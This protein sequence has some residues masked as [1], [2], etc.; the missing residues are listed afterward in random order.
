[1]G[2]LIL[3]EGAGLPDV[4][5]LLERR[6]G[7]YFVKQY[8]PEKRPRPAFHRH[9]YGQNTMPVLAFDLHRTLTPDIGYPL[10]SDPFPGL[11]EGMDQFVARGCCLHVCTASMDFPDQQIDDAR[12]ALATHWMRAKGLP[13]TFV[14]PNAEASS[15][16]D[17]RGITVPEDPDW[18]SLWAQAEKQ[19][20]KT[21]VI[22]KKSGKYVRRDDLNPAGRK[23]DEDEY[24]DGEDV[25]MDCPRGFTTPLI[26]IDLHRTL[27]PGWGTRRDAE[28][29]ADGVRC[30]RE[31]YEKG[32]T[33]QI[34]CAG[35]NPALVDDPKFAEQRSAWQRRYLLQ[36]GIP[37]DR[38]VTKDDYDVWF[39]DRVI[40]YTGD[41]EAIDAQIESMYGEEVRSWPS[42]AVGQ[43]PNAP[44]KNVNIHAE[45]HAKQMSELRESYELT[46]AG[47]KGE[48]AATARHR[49]ER[50]AEKDALIA[51]LKTEAGDLRAQFI[52]LAR[53][54][55]MPTINV[56]VP[57]REIHVDAPV[58]VAPVVVN[59]QPKPK[60]SRIQYDGINRI[61]GI[62]HT[63]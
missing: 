19:L 45:L 49:D 54:G 29:E 6:K 33:I 18:P 50:E 57:E 4:S 63:Y 10:V 53:E 38:L 41:W 34:S 13:V 48:M 42:A 14:G 60:K 43:I 7:R 31:W 58:S 22:D 32:Y 30:I 5:L 9:D 24:P 46:L 11:K 12:H 1:M 47:L 62:E 37:Y 25:P 27:M 28:P 17:D 59:Q 61:A 55:A 52:A 21:Y 26:D 36:Y 56:T 20:A 2:K 40:P 8:V 51:Q 16:I 44:I 3:E 39:D 23:I 15:R 35:W